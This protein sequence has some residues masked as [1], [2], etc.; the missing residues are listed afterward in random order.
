MKQQIYTL[1]GSVLMAAAAVLY[2]AVARF[3]FGLAYMPGLLGI[4]L[5]MLVSFYLQ[6]V[7]H[8]LG[9]LVFGLLTGYRFVSIRF[10]N[11]LFTLRDGKLK[12]SRYHLAGTGGQ[13]LMDPPD[14]DNGNFPLKLYNYG[15]IL[16]NLISSVVF[17]LMTAIPF[18][19][20]VRCFFLI[21]AIMGVVLAV[22]NGLPTVSRGVPN[23]GMNAIYAKDPDA[24]FSLWTQLKVAAILGRGGSYADVPRW[25]GDNAENID[26]SNALNAFRFALKESFLVGEWKLAEAEA[27]L[28]R[29]EGSGMSGI[30]KDRLELD[31]ITF[32]LLRKDRKKAKALTTD[33]MY[34]F[35]KQNGSDPIV[36]RTAYIMDLSKG[37]NGVNRRE[38][39]QSVKKIYPYPQSLTVDEYLMNYADYI[40]SQPTETPLT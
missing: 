14:Y 37:K 2:I 11:T 35:M 27:L 5:M 15:G 7:I 9:H 31:H 13:C 38:L 29:M 22:G 12:R 26:L 20:P 4:G 3:V 8:E 40:Y 1:I 39:F 16:M 30:Q 21:L 17:L 10:L 33:H 25:Y 32:A 34:L 23:D 36:I 24:K 28:D 6:T 19:D 18:P